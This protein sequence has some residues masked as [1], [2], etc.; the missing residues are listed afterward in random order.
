M[1]LD[2]LAAD[3][4][5]EARP[6]DALGCEEGSTEEL[7]RFRTHTRTRIR[8]SDASVCTQANL[9]LAEAFLRS[10]RFGR[11]TTLPEWDESCLSCS[12]RSA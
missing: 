1:T 8:F 9:T 6:T 10:A 7:H 4:K 3:P 5:T 11:R 12:A 2:D